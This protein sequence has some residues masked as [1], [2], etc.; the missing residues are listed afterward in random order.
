VNN[1]PGT[2][3]PSINGKTRSTLV[4]AD[5]VA[6]MSLSLL[7]LQ[8]EINAC[9]GFFEQQLLNVNPEKSEVICFIRCRGVE[10]SCHLDFRGTPRENVQ[11]A[12]YLG[13]FFDSRGTWKCQ[14]SVVL[15][16][17][18]VALGRCKVIVSTVGTG[19]AKYAVNMFDVL[20]SSVYRYGFGAWGPVGGNLN[21]FDEL[22]VGFVRWLFR[23]PKSTSKSNILGCF[24]RRCAICDSIYLAAVQLAGAEVSRNDLW[25]DLVKDLLSRKIKSKWFDKVCEALADRGVYDKVFREGVSLV[26]LRK[27]FGVQMAQF[28]FHNHLNKLTNTS[29]DDFRRVKPFGVYPF[30]FRTQPVRSRFLFSFLLCNWRWIDKGKCKTYPRFC[31]ECRKDNTAWHIIFECL[32]FSDVR[33]SFFNV[34]GVHFE[35]EALF[36]DDKCVTSK[37][38]DAGE[39]IYQRVARLCV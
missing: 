20:V 21:C 31:S 15:S 27:E 14:K 4:Y 9:Y 35:Y 8:V 33:E 10:V 36:I 12:R 2:A 28:C 17:S 19:N 1:T 23:F 26:A 5:D 13:V 6:E 3:A 34:T 24:G 16:R 25:K 29:A 18:R 37:A 30:L 7:G 38:V 32:I 39:K 11:V 22:F